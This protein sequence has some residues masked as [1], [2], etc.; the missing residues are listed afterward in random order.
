MGDV[1]EPFPLFPLG[2]VLLPRETV[3]LH[4]FEQRYRTMIGECLDEEREFGIVWLGEGG[5]RDVGCR[6]RITEVLERMPDGRMNI[7]VEGTGPFRLLRRIE[8]L[9][10]PA[11]QVELVE[12]EPEDEDAEATAAARARYADLVEKATD[13][14]PE[15]E[16]LERLDSYGMAAT[17]DFAL[18]AK[19]QLLEL[20]SESGRL[21][22][23]A[24]MF[25]HALQ[26]ME[27]AAQ[28]A[29]RAQGN[30]KVRFGR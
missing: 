5:L 28:A 19:Q 3:P 20:R 9:E 1:I 14:R 23:L 15:P 30:G 13:T 17:L 4:I 21:E 29:E 8:E 12:D 22:Q 2:L 11:G 6:A 25:E 7:L 10:Y 18:D 27:K 16:D 24:E 26:R